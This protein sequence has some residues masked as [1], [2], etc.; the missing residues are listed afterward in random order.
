M[1]ICG[2]CPAYGRIKMYVEN[3]TKKLT[4]MA[5]FAALAY[6]LMLVGRIPI[7][8]MSFLKYDPKDL[9]LAVSG[10]VLGPIPALLISTVVCLIEMVTVSDTGFI[11]FFMNLLAS[12]CFA[13]PAAFF[14]KRKHSIRGGILGL[15]IGVVLMTVAMLLW[16]YFLTPLYMGWPREEIAAMLVPIFLPFNLIKGCINAALTVLVYKPV[17]KALKRSGLAASRPSPLAATAKKRFVGVYIAAAV[18]LISC[19]FAVLVWMGI[20]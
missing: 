10:F 12:A 5:M 11:G 9:I 3:K 15:T 13:C 17:S 1:Q 20:I 18:V 19:V 7:S 14:Y 6:V 4:L 8:P 16:N 2:L